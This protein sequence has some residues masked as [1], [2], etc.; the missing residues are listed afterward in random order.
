MQRIAVLEKE[1]CAR[2]IIFEMT[3]ILGDQPAI[4]AHFMKIS[5]FAKADASTN[6]DIVFFNEMFENPRVSASFV[7]NAPNRIV[8]Y[9]VEKVSTQLYD[10]SSTSRILYMNRHYIKQEMKRIRPHIEVLMRLHEEYF[11]SYNNVH[12]PLRIQKIIY[13]EKS[14]KNV[15]YHTTRGD[16]TERK[17]MIDAENVFCK[18]DFVRIHASYL[19]NVYYIT[20]INN[21]FMELSNREEL[22]ISRSRK[23]EVID[24]F[25]SFVKR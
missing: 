20:R 6:F 4:Y 3:K 21:E 22:P 24:W 16:F 13:I 2:E 9:C 23:N 14:E 11:L 25:H 17:T 15:I 18:Y 8:I 5:A 12:L 10:N 19:V 1:S 7:E